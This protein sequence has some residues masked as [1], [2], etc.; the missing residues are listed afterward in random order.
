MSAA[1]VCASQPH[2]CWMLMVSS[3]FRAVALPSL[4]YI[5]TMEA[6]LKV[7]INQSERATNRT[8]FCALSR[9][10]ETSM[11]LGTETFTGTT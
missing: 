6:V 4:W 2:G 10:P 1:A 8:S 11:M 3:Q 7:L 9:S 5:A